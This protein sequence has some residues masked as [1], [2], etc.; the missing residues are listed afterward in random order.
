MNKYRKIAIIQIL[1][2]VLI[3]VGVILARIEVNSESTYLR[4]LFTMFLLVLAFLLFKI[5]KNLFLY[6][7]VKILNE[8]ELKNYGIRFV[9]NLSKNNLINLYNGNYNLTFKVEYNSKEYTLNSK[10]IYSEQY[11]T[12]CLKKKKEVIIFVNHLNFDN[13]LILI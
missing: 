3:V 8:K 10:E 7:N 9:L 12:E 6:K 1:T 4:T 13:Y 11:I 2:I 5:N